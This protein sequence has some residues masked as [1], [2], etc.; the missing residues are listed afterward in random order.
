M[1]SFESTGTDSSRGI[2]GSESHV[3]SGAARSV[4]LG[5]RGDGWAWRRRWERFFH[6]GT[7]ILLI[8]KF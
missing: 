3:G 8:W 1:L 5:E 2:T 4:L 7:G 6:V